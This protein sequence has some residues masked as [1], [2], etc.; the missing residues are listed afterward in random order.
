[1]ARIVIT[2][3]TFGAEDRD[4]GRCK[5]ALENT[6]VPIVELEDCPYID[7]SRAC[8]VE[9]AFEHD[10]NLDVIVWIDHDIIF[11]A[12]D[13]IALAERCHASEQY[14]ILGVL[15]SMRR[16]KFTTIGR[17]ADHV[18]QA[19]FY[20]PGQIDGLF[21]G[22]GMT[23]VKRAVF[24]KMRETLP[25]LDCPTVGRK[26]HPYFH[27][28]MDGA[29]LGEDIS[30]CNRAIALGFRVGIDTEPR[31]LHRGRYDYALE[32]CGIAVPDFPTLIMNFE[33][34]LQVQVTD[35]V[36]DIT[37]PRVSTQEPKAAE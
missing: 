7:M 1:M 21:V 2:K 11:R 20:A 23:A 24:L 28:S 30:F 37:K 27:H 10:P 26:V 25:Y 6:G 32:D 3:P 16:P 9:R 33:R 13:V 5:R 14:D 15:Y 4:H 18:K 31:I 34:G 12:S 19:E 35:R 17:P 22:L 8:L 29:Y 36:S